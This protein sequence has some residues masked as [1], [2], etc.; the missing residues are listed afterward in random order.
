MFT[1]FEDL[2]WHTTVK[3]HNRGKSTN[4]K[5]LLNRKTGIILSL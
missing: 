5:G 4:E 3:Y 2:K 1:G